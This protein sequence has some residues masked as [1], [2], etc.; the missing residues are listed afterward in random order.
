MIKLIQ[1][2]DDGSEMASIEIDDFT[3]EVVYSGLAAMLHDAAA[4]RLPVSAPSCDMS[5]QA[6]QRRRR[7]LS[8][9]RD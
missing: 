2:A 7:V 5:R 9:L 1:L 3:V 8:R 4:A 6:L